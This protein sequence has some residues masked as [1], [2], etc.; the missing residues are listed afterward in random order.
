MVIAP[1][2]MR[3]M[4]SEHIEQAFGRCPETERWLSRLFVITRTD[5]R[6]HSWPAG[7][8]DICWH[9]LEAICESLT[10]HLLTRRQ[11]RLAFE[12]DA[13]AVNGNQTADGKGRS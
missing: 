1:L 6:S 2:A 5:M 13:F 11:Y 8:S 10:T 3:R 9:P 4:H 7:P 12:A